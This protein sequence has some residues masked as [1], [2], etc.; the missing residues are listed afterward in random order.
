VLVCALKMTNNDNV[1]T[2]IKLD[3]SNYSMEISNERLLF[4]KDLYDSIE[5]KVIKPEDNLKEIGIS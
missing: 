1:G 3:S 4:C 5:E 2:M